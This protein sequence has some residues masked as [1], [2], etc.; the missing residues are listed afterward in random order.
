M[1]NCTSHFILLFFFIT[2]PC[3]ADSKLPPCASDK[4]VD[5]WSNCIGT[6]IDSI[7]GKYIGEWKNGSFHG[8]GTTIFDEKSRW[9]GDKY[10]GGWKDGKKYGQ[11]TYTYAD[12]SIKQGIWYNDQFLYPKKPEKTKNK[13]QKINKKKPDI[14]EDFSN[15]PN[16]PEE[17]PYNEWTKC[18]GSHTEFNLEKIPPTVRIKA[19]NYLIT[20]LETDPTTVNQVLTD[21]MTGVQVPDETTFEVVNI[22]SGYG[23]KYEGTWK[24]GKFHGNGTATFGAK[25][26]WAKEKYVGEFKEG[27]RHGQGT[28]TYTDRS[29]YI[30]TFVN[31]KWDGNGILTNSFGDKYTGEFKNGKRHGKG[32]LTNLKGESYTGTF[33]ND[34][35]IGDGRL[36]F[37]KEKD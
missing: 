19:R 15:L 2:T 9:A 31:G 21:L 25:T 6:Y 20:D 37:P 30:G 24:D 28:Y 18:F 32:T 36:G 26:R 27:K 3:F 11:G 12:K 35:A 16:C 7:G 17:K 29:K 4:S 1:N 14:K 22:L 13:V 34:I 23:G 10:V 33:L 5:S 8:H